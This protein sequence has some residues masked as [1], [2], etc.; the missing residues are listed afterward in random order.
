MSELEGIRQAA[1][2][3]HRTLLSACYRADPSLS[4]RLFD[5]KLKASAANVAK[6]VEVSKWSLRKAR[7]D[8]TYFRCAGTAGIAAPM[9]VVC[10][11]SSFLGGPHAALF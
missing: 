3:S 8:P 5:H 4:T 11:N 2:C 7:E 10:K 1:G 9:L 6:R